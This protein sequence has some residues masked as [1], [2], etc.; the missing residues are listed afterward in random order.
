M[1][2]PFTGGSTTGLSATDACGQSRQPVII[3]NSLNSVENDPKRPSYGKIDL[4]I[5]R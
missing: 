1:L 5:A 2:P 3:V 4:A